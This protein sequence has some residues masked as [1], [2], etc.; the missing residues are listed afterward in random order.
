[1]NSKRN[2]IS[3]TLPYLRVIPLI[4]LGILSILA[5]RLCLIKYARTALVLH[6][7]LG[8]ALLCACGKPTMTRENRT[9]AERHDQLIRLSSLSPTELKYRLREHFNENILFCGPHVGVM[10]VHPDERFKKFSLIRRNTEEFHAILRHQNLT[11]TPDWADQDMMSVLREHY[12]LSAIQLEPAGEKYKFRLRLPKTE[13][14]GPTSQD[15]D[16]EPHL[17]TNAFFIVG[18][19]DHKKGVII[20][21]SKEPIIHTCPK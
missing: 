4:I 6:A 16:G 19:I 11:D 1:M 2:Q 9:D 18:F 20:I 13:A 5:T 12:V 21:S 7:V 17:P 8:L 14:N 3:T 15:I 10:R